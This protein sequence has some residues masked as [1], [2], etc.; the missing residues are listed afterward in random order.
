ML[1]DFELVASDDPAK[2]ELELTC[3]KC[4]AHV[5][6]VEAGDGL[7]TLADMADAHSNLLS[8]RKTMLEG[9]GEV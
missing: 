3:L 1:D 5:C 6:D 9:T 8:C 7:Q 4:G 2:R